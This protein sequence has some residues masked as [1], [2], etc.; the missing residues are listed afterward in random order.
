MI[1]FRC[2]LSEG[3]IISGIYASGLVSQNVLANA[4]DDVTSRKVAVGFD[5]TIGCS[6]H[7]VFINQ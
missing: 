2:G 6:N 4:A 3:L 5:I 1:A 7:F